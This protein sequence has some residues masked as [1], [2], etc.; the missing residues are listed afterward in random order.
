MTYAVVSVVAFAAVAVAAAWPYL[1]Q[2]ARSAG[3]SA[4][5][6]A[7]WVNRLFSL[8]SQADAEG[9]AQIASAA[10]AL[11][12]ALVSQQEAVKRGR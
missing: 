5:E 6:R 4:A 10:R 11:I 8:A 3:I 12:A 9:E 1:P 2:M 7:G